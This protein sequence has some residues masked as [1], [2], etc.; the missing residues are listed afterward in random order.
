M[1]NRFKRSLPRIARFLFGVVHN[2]KKKKV[3]LVKNIKTNKLVWKF[4]LLVWILIFTALFLNTT[5]FG[6]KLISL[7]TAVKSFLAIQSPSPLPTNLPISTISPTTTLKPYIDPNP[8]IT[9]NIHAS[10]GG[11]SQQL[12]KNVCD[13]M[14]CCLIDQK[15]GGPK[16]IAISECNNNICCGL[17]D[18]SWT[19]T[20]SNQ[21]NSI[22]NS[23]KTDT[24]NSN[25]NANM[26]PCEIY[27]AYSNK[28]EIYQLTPE[29]CVYYKESAKPTTYTT[30]PIITPIPTINPAV[31]QQRL[32]DIQRCK[33]S[34][35]SKYDSQATTLRNQYRAAGALSSSDYGLATQ[36][37]QSD[38]QYW[39][40]LCENA[41]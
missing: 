22:H 25:T 9:C 4:V 21:C 19:F 28:T 24:S 11:G 13:S 27:W 38:Y 37:L 30:L 31:E 18:G 10:C 8:I 12:R 14:N 20:S 3:K 6:A 41:Y 29:Q 7:T 15:C 35:K 36:R 5:V 16:F 40:Y 34:A 17:K 33:D 39:L 1:K 26:I 23:Y 32:A 2:P